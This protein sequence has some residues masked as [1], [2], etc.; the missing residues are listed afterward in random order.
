MAD[1]QPPA[2]SH[3]A[4]APWSTGLGL[5]VP[6]GAVVAL[7][8]VIL[9]ALGGVARWLLFSEDG[10][11]WALDRVP[12]VQATGFEGALLGDRWRADKL[13]VRIPGGTTESVTLE[14]LD[15]QAGRGGPG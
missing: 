14:G 2:P 10:A 11:R 7:L 3:A 1:P 15:A 13:V 9:L 4:P 8:L 6:L 12:W 5:L